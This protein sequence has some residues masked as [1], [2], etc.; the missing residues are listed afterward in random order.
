M[1][2]AQIHNLVGTAKVWTDNSH[3]NLEMISQLLPNCTYDKQKF[4]AITIC[5]LIISRRVVG[6]CNNN[7]EWEISKQCFYS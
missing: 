5:L 6:F 2:V 4:A 7:N 3:F 1:P